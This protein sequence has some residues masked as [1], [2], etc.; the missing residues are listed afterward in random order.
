MFSACAYTDSCLMRPTSGAL[1]EI[2][3]PLCPLSYSKIRI[4][5]AVD[6]AVDAIIRFHSGI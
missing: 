5:D 1:P 2:I 3:A 4:A 6:A